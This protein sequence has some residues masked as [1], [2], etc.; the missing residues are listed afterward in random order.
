M[1]DS[2]LYQMDKI[3]FTANGLSV[4]YEQ[5]LQENHKLL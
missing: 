1:C 5:S 3:V 4:E 2:R